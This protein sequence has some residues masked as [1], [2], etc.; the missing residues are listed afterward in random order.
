MRDI[1]TKITPSTP[2]R[3]DLELVRTSAYGEAIAAQLR[4]HTCGSRVA[5]GMQATAGAREIPAATAAAMAAAS[6]RDPSFY[7]PATGGNFPRHDMLRDNFFRAG[8]QGQVLR[9]DD[10]KANSEKFF[11][12]SKPW[13]SQWEIHYPSRTAD[14]GQNFFKSSVAPPTVRGSSRRK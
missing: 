7:R 6:G 12:V 14:R 13:H 11:A 10:G 5:A 3:P 8:G 9:S 4:P 2:Q 1:G